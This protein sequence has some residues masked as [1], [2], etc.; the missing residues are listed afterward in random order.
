MV[1]EKMCR[2]VM[3]QLL[4]KDVHLRFSENAVK[5]LTILGY[6]PLNGARPMRRVL[7][8]QVSRILADELLFGQLSEGGDVLITAH[9]DWVTH[10]ED[11]Q[12][13]DAEESSVSRK[14]AAPK[15]DAFIVYYQ[16]EARTHSIWS[17]ALSLSSQIDESSLV[18]DEAPL[19]HNEE[20]STVDEIEDSTVLEQAQ[21]AMSLL[22]P[23]DSSKS[24]GED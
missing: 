4:V 22:S 23:I 17:S 13:Y 19:D 10:L 3:T 5:A 21:D 7:R 2:E 16:E 8:D 18:V 1:A 9:E 11:L 6:D 15:T 12:N 14:P 24:E 20:T